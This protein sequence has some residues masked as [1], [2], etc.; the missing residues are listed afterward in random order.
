MKLFLP[1]IFTI[2]KVIQ[3]ILL[4]PELFAIKLRE[5]KDT[6]IK[7]KYIKLVQLQQESQQIYYNFPLPVNKI[8]LITSYTLI[9]H[10]CLYILKHNANRLPFQNSY[11]NNSIYIK[12]IYN[13]YTLTS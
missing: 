1:A 11:K 3:T 7:K 8:C 6:I 5:I 9:I 2:I 12:I 13:V 10:W 4:L